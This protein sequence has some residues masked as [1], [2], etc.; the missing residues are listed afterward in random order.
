MAVRRNHKL[1]KEFT[2]PEI[3]AGTNRVIHLTQPA[4]DVLKNQA[5]ITR[6]G[7]AEHDYAIGSVNQIW[8]G[9]MR[10]DGIRYRKAYQ[11]LHTYACWSLTAG[12]NPDFI[13][14]PQTVYRVYGSWMAEKNQDQVIMLNQKL[15][16]FAPSVPHAM[17]SDV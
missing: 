12:A 16:D 13:V 4:I 17:G 1:T 7:R 11:S 9:A 3:D 6:N 2:L 15:A 10:H 14:R 5:E 8:E